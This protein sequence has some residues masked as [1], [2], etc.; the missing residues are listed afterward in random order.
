ML[1]PD[2]VKPDLIAAVK[3]SNPT[4]E[5]AS[6]IALLEK[7]D[8]TAAPNSKGAEL[9]EVWW[10]YYS[11]LR[12]GERPVLL[13]DDKR[14]AKVWSAADPLKTPSGLADKQR[15]VDSFTW[16]VAETARRYGS[17]DVAWGDVHRVRRGKV[18]VPVGGC[19]NDLGCFR[20]LTFARD[21]DAKLSANSGDGWILAIE[22]SDTPR[23]Y[24]VLAYGE[25]R[26]PESPWF[27]DQAE[28]F[29]KG[30]VKKVAFTDADVS[31]T[32]VL[33]YRP[34]EK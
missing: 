21:A 28:M 7:W 16:A 2:R 25:S 15:A 26:R 10:N 3:A 32:A 8:N 33:R 17:W 4:G 22:F 27:A 1:L 18:D 20:I 31:A 29:A 13:P 23:A 12:A 11:G 34:G 30:E 14:F 9:F 24:S 6:A 5:V 19:S